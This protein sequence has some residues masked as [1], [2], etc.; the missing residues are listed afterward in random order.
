[1]TAASD[2]RASR[3]GDEDFG[4]PVP[5][6]G[7]ITTIPHW[8]LTPVSGVAE[9]A[10]TVPGDLMT[11]VHRLAEDMAVPT[12][13][14]LLAAHA[15]VLAALSG[16]QQVTTGYLAEPGAR[17]LPCRLTTDPAT[18]KA[19]IRE[20]RRG[21]SELPAHRCARGGDGPCDPGLSERLTE[22]SFVPFPAGRRSGTGEGG[23]ELPA[24]TVVQVVAPGSDSGPVLRLRYRRDALDARS[25]ARIAGYHRPVNNVDVRVVDENL[26][27][28]PLGAPGE[29]V[30]AGV[31]VGRG[32]VNDPDRTRRSFTTDPYRTGERLHRSGDYGR[33]LPGG[34]LEFLGRRDSQVKIRGFRVEIEEVENALL[35]VPGVH[36]AAVTVAQGDRGPR[37]VA[38][39]C[40]EHPLP[41]SVLRDHLGKRLPAYMIPSAFHWRDGLPL[42]ANGK[43]DRKALASLARGLDTTWPLVT[44]DA[45]ASPAGEPPRTPTEERLA[46]AWATVLGIPQHRIGRRDHFFD[47]AGCTSLTAL[48]L[49]IRL[50]R[51]V[52]LKDLTHHPVLADL[53]RLLDARPEVITS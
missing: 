37:L 16:E 49:A 2:V 21:E 11:S 43:V 23:G 9:H 29:I 35:N 48:Q 6:R 34:E 13:S 52:S 28:V 17:P 3:L 22:A 4:R 24:G 12:R 47:D 50:D 1:M 40:G 26:S 44:S 41:D 53:A 8:T 32:Y 30:F 31:C 27:L 5:P 38:C 7:G 46:A 51:T 33:W 19:L 36:T 20:A 14:V 15:K 45:A 18:W 25:A 10:V 39:C 42:T